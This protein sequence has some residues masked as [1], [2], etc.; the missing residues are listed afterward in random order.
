M[1]G[2]GGEVG[3]A[4]RGGVEIEEGAANLDVCC[5]EINTDILHNSGSN[6]NV[7]R[8]CLHLLVM[9]SLSRRGV[10]LRRITHGAQLIV[11]ILHPRSIVLSLAPISCGWRGLRVKG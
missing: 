1:Y 6:S 2:S 11:C 3:G 8:G 10:L 9:S 7:V 4:G 5:N